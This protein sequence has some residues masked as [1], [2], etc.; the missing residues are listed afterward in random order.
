VYA[1]LI[2]GVTGIDAHD[3][4]V[5]L[6]GEGAGSEVG[7]ELADLAISGTGGRE[8]VFEPILDGLRTTS[9]GDIKVHLIRA[10]DL[11]PVDD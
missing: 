9:F 6:L 7:I 5:S 10:S 2:R 11:P 1:N 3:R 8:D 4:I